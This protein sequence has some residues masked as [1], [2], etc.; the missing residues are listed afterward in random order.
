MK[1]SNPID[2][3]KGGQHGEKEP[4]SSWIITLIGIISLGTGYGIAL[5]V[6]TP[7]EALLL[8]FVAVVFVIIGTYALFI[9]G[10]ITLLKQLKKIKSFI[11][12]P[13]ISFPCLG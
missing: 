3:L 8:F 9:S 2:L 10:S 7:L 5:S 11:I 6:E 13:G 12:S 1:L 4:K